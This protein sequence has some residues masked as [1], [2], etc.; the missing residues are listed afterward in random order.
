[1]TQ[2]IRFIPGALQ[3]TRIYGVADSEYES[4]ATDLDTSVAHP[5]VVLLFRN[6]SCSSDRYPKNLKTLIYLISDYLKVS[7]PTSL[8]K[9]K[10]S[11]QKK[12]AII[13]GK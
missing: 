6:A 11:I 5:Q 3:S 12:L 2:H 4:T 10:N 9:W 8:G 7:L 1:M 13:F